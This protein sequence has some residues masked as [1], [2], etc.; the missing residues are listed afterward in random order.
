MGKSLLNLESS[1]N[2]ST[3]MSL[4]KPITKFVKNYWDMGAMALAGFAFGEYGNEFFKELQFP[5]MFVSGFGSLY[6]ARNS[7]DRYGRNI[8]AGIAGWC[9]SNID[10]SLEN[11][12]WA[13]LFGG[14]SLYFDGFRRDKFIRNE[15][16]SEIENLAK[17]S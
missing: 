15:K 2:K 11:G 10:S 4:K 5:I 9:C 6:G 17:L 8:Y 14:V 7:C 3:I 12:A 16:I 1:L 13:V